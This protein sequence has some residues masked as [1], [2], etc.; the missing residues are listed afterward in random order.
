[1]PLAPRATDGRDGEPRVLPGGSLTGT[2]ALFFLLSAYWSCVCVV[3]RVVAP[4]LPR[5]WPMPV[6]RRAATFVASEGADTSCSPTK[7]ACVLNSA[8]RCAVVDVFYHAGNVSAAHQLPSLF[9]STNHFLLS[10]VSLTCRP[11]AVPQVAAHQEEARQ[12]H[13][14]E[15]PAAPVDPPAHGQHDPLQ[16][17]ASSLAP[18]QA[19][20]VRMSP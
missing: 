8:G 5:S 6:R 19:R 4:C 7:R 12:G 16:Q 1:M 14:A 20:P 11:A 15:P 10:A 9:S 2:A 13:Q 3:A 18:H 17:Q